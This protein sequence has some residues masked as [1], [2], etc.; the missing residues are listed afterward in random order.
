[1][2]VNIYN[3]SQPLVA[4][5][6][7]TFTA[8]L[9]DATNQT[10][11]KANPTLAAGVVKV[12]V[13]GGAQSNITSLPTH[14]AL[15]QLTVSLSALETAGA[16]KNITVTF[17]DA[18]GSEWLDCAYVIDVESAVSGSSLAADI[19]DLADAIE[20]GLTLRQAMR[21]ALAVLAGKISGGGTS[22][23]TF[24]NAVAD[25]KNRVVATVDASGNRT[26]IT[27]DVS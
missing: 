2:T 27:T 15:G 6:A 10:A 11:F 20:T 22:T 21:L 3:N 26:A 23:E 9:V 25:S 14:V 7:F 1:M 5:S 8:F 12:S 4:G 13:D 16:T 24:R 18:A 17:H 19:V